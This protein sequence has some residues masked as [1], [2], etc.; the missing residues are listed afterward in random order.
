M[1]ATRSLFNR[2][3]RPPPCPPSRRLLGATKAIAG[4]RR[5]T[6]IS[7]V[8]SGKSDGVGSLACVNTCARSVIV[9]PVVPWYRPQAMRQR[10]GETAGAGPTEMTV[11]ELV[12]AAHNS[13]PMRPLR[14]AAPRGTQFP[15]PRWAGELPPPERR[16]G[17]RL[18]ST[19]IPYMAVLDVLDLFVK[20]RSRRRLHDFAHHLRRS[21]DPYHIDGG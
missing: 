8:P 19:S 12:S 21:H 16:T 9:G 2:P 18:E 3:N 14:V 13:G 17:G 5:R 4:K 6:S 1:K 15:A 11:H 20:S 10:R 7:R